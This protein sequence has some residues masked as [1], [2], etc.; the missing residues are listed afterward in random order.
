MRDQDKTK[1]QLIEEL[2][3][4]RKNLSESEERLLRES[5]ERYRA[6]FENMTEGFAI[7]EIIVD[8]DGKPCDYR[9]LEIN[10]AFE[11]LTGLKRHDLIGKRALEVLPGT[12]A[13]WIDSFG[14]VALTGESLHME[15]Y[16]SELECW[17]EVF[18]YRT[19]P[20]QFAVVFTNINE[21]KRMGE[22]LLAAKAEAECRAKEAEEGKCILDALMNHIP[23]G[24]TIAS[25]PNV[26]TTHIS[27]YGHDLLCRGWETTAGFSM[28]E[29]LSRVEHFLPDGATP[30]RVEDLPLWRAVK[31][32]ETI[33]GQELVLR[34][35]KGYLFPVLCNAGPIRD[36]DGKITGGVVA[37]RDIA[38]RRRAEDALREARNE[39]QRRAHEA[40]ERERVLTAMME[41]IP[42]GIT[43]ADAPDVTIRAVSRFGRELTGR[44]PEQI[45]GISVDLHPERWNVYHA[46]GATPATNEE[47]PLTR[48]TQKGEI[49]RDEVWV[50]GREDGTRIP[51]LCTAAPIRD[52]QGH[53]TGGVIGWQDITA[54]KRAEREIDAAITEAIN[55]K[56]R[57]EAVMEALPVGVAI[58]DTLGGNV[59]SNPA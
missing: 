17:Y 32:G 44:S 4:L 39:A 47:L 14:R 24:I 8:T 30:A 56:N 48:A 19:A 18:A 29:W 12:E 21:R 20:G 59:K 51:I 38:E 9:F 49:I 52:V 37:W 58:V 55:E 45:E 31:Y 25:A 16:S 46:D 42:M 40:E 6:L 23:E 27:N 43:I 2:N 5:D 3:A 13:Y 57:L 33:M 1:E 11:R 22:E 36:R 35:P 54:R 34:N 50:L 26:I 10:P 7:H 15:Q 53:I 41:H 28:E